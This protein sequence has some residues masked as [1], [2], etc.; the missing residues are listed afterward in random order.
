M[1]DIK[2]IKPYSGSTPISI[3]F[4]FYEGVEKDLAFHGVSVR[5]FVMLAFVRTP[6]M[7]PTDSNVAHQTIEIKAYRRS[8]W[9]NISA[10]PLLENSEICALRDAGRDPHRTEQICE[11]P[12]NCSMSSSRTLSAP[13][14]TNLQNAPSMKLH[15]PS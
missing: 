2:G 5:E 6:Q 8:L 1:D 13:R 9:F 12:K 15:R 7:A 4:D 10:Y 3:R 11:A 14:S